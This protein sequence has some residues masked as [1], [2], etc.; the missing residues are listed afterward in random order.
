MR[1]R[2]KLMLIV[3]IPLIAALV[4]A[5]P[6]LRTRVHDLDA[7]AKAQQLVGPE[8]RVRTLLARIDDEASLSAW[9]TASGDPVPQ[10][11]LRAARAATDR[12]AA[13][14][15]ATERDASR[16]GA[17]GAARGIH[18]LRETLA[19][20]GQQRQ[21]VDLRLLPDGSALGYFRDLAGS[22][23]DIVDAFAR[24]PQGAAAAIMFRDQA[25]LARLQAA[26]A[27]ERS[28]LAVAY[29]RHA[30]SDALAS[31]LVAAVTSQNAALNELESQGRA[32]TRLAVQ[33]GIE[34]FRGA[35][36]Q[37]RQRRAAALSNRLLPGTVT[38]E[39]WYTTAS[40]QLHG[41]QSVENRI[42][43]GIV[44][45]LA[46]RHDDA[47][48]NLMVVGFGSIAV[49]LLAAGLAFVVARATTRPLRQLADNAHD[50]AT[51]Q[52]PALVDALH[53]PRAEPPTI[54]PMVVRSRDELGALAKAFNHVE[55]T[56]VEVA[57]LQRDAVRTGISDL[58][59]N[60]ARRNQPL[61]TRQLAVIE[62][63]ER[64]ERDS[65]RLGALFT[66]DH[67]ATRMRRNS[68]SLL[69]LAGVDDPTVAQRAVPLL[70]VVRGAISETTDFQRIDTA[71]IA[72]DVDIVGYAAPDLA[73]AISELLENATTFSTPASRVVVTTRTTDAGIELTISDRGIGIPAERMTELNAT[74]ADPPAPGLVLSRSLGLIVVARL[75]RRIGVRVTLR[76]APDV[77]TAAVMVL[78][79]SIV[80]DRHANAIDLVAEESPAVPEVLE[81]ATAPGEDGAPV[82]VVGSERSAP[83]TVPPAAD[84]APAAPARAGEG[85]VLPRRERRLHRRTRPHRGEPTPAVG[86][87]SPQV[88]APPPATPP[89]AA[90]PLAAAPNPDGDSAG[91]GPAPTAPD[92]TT[93]A[94]L[95][96]RTPSATPDPE[97][98]AAVTVPP[99]RPPDAVFELI[100][101]YEA[102]RRRAHQHPSDDEEEERP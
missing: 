8:T 40:A 42:T 95:P 79:D 45:D 86:T 81:P 51:R 102:G 39:E 94:G 82:V 22:T 72:R 24:A 78:P 41:W 54:T 28:I 93:T 100:A 92:A 33:R 73:H 34:Q 71:G 56:T 60:L 55:R 67:L 21:F 5:I 59:V 63:L 84:I 101:R 10:S 89:Q 26:L 18:D 47:R 69:V 2:T 1:F 99:S 29:S 38:P 6:G 75:T 31:D 19:L 4:V 90:P 91:A 98:P 14:M 77:G 80:R 23:T 17:P 13:A 48:T 35:T 64:E 53:D 62:D 3:A 15:P 30:L 27:D 65:D 44:H 37:V 12:A 83:R 50:V 25:T 58:Y 87:P 66:L 7:T 97:A 61:L 52:L 16:A 76:S 96:R 88:P 20:L 46:R 74:L 9:W 43:A 70:D 85:E 11:R 68:D 49:L 57:E 32:A 36:D